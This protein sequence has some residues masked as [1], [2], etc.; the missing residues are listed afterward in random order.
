MNA[1]PCRQLFGAIPK[2]DDEARRGFLS[3]PQR[4]GG[5]IESGGSLWYQM[6][7][8]LLYYRT[9]LKPN[10]C[11]KS[12]PHGFTFPCTHYFCQSSPD[13]VLKFWTYRNRI[14]DHFAQ[15]S[16]DT[17]RLFGDMPVRGGTCIHKEAPPFQSDSNKVNPR[18]GN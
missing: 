9:D 13:D 17:F 4:P 12:T 8:L 16:H 10:G 6:L 7:L 11:T 1:E 3:P 2:V 15:H 5:R 14:S 18:H